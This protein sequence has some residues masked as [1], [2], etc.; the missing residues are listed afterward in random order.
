MNVVISS[1]QQI[2]LNVVTFDPCKSLYEK[3]LLIEVTNHDKVFQIADTIGTIYLPEP[4][5]YRLKVL[6]KDYVNLAHAEKQ[7][8][9]TEGQNYDTLTRTTIGLCLKGIHEP[10]CGYFCCDR[11][12]EGHNVDYFTNGQK[13]MEG[14]FM[15]GF[16]IGQLIFYNPDG[17]IREIQHYD[18][19]GKGKL[20]KKETFK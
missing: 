1:G 17:T 11:L 12:C 13:M 5:T 8:E 16:P 18:K 20:E 15:N 14:E 10:I 2:K 7:I 9:I 6:L 3:E 4:G 19:W